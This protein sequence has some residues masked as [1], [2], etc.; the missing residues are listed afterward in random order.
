MDGLITKKKEWYKWLISKKKNNGWEGSSQ[1]KFETNPA[2]VPLCCNAKYFSHL[3]P[4]TLPQVKQ[5]TGMIMAETSRE[6]GEMITRWWSQMRVVGVGAETIWWLSRKLFDVFLN[7][8]VIFI[9]LGWQPA[10]FNQSLSLNQQGKHM[11]TGFPQFKVRNL[12]ID[13]KNQ[14]GL[15]LFWIETWKIMFPR[16]GRMIQLSKPLCSPY[17]FPV[18]PFSSL[19][20]SSTLRMVVIARRVGVRIFWPVWGGYWW[21][22]QPAW[23]WLGF[24]STDLIGIIR[25]VWYC[26]RSGNCI[27]SIVHSFTRFS[28]NFVLVTRCL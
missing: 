18:P 9:Q 14:S 12:V 28:W 5:R 10:A 2:S 15:I 6:N 16:L 25:L 7:R 24:S 22:R 20:Y 23:A 1:L 8:R 27:I 4:I 21:R 11:S 3:F 17:C 26:S 13:I 19:C